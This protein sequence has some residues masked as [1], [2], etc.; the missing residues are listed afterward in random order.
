MTLSGIISADLFS[1]LFF[2]VGGGVFAFLLS[3]VGTFG[4]IAISRKLG[5]LDR[6]T[7]ERRRIHKVPVPRLGGVAIFLAFVVASLVFYT[8]DAEVTA[9]EMVRY[10]LL[11]AAATLIVLVHIY[12]DIKGLKPLPKLIAQT[13][14]VIIILG[15]F[16]TQFHGV[17]LFGFSNPFGIPG[18]QNDPAILWY[19]KPVLTLFINNPD[20]TLMAIPAVLFT[21]FW[22]VAMMNTVNFI[23]GVDGLATGVT[24]ITGLFIVIICLT[25]RQYSIAVLSA[26]FTG[27][28]LGFLPHNWNPAKIF[29]GDTGSQFLGL[30]LAVLSVIGGAKV[31]L[32]LMLLGIPILDVVIVVVS[33][34]RRGRS[35]AQHDTTSHLHYRLLAAGLTAKQ[36]CYVFYGLTLIFGV[37]ALEFPRIYKLIG[38]A[39]VIITMAALSIWIDYRQRT[40]GVPA[41][42]TTQELKEETSGG[43]EQDLSQA[44]KAEGRAR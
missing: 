19:H 32:A 29:M 18:S 2:I 4:V 8:L 24:A 37:L 20:I 42:P 44:D 43:S 16:G 22:I 30:C 26:I 31:A 14:A 15:P 3:F 25:L 28:V 23:D 34:L 6:S 41:Q 38:I 36:I 5:W 12:D 9:V 10:W 21:W 27:A 39:L 7:V 33:R 40:R 17:L 11:L 13:I 35:V 1:Q